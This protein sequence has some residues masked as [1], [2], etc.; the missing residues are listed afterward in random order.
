MP[1]HQSSRV[2]TWCNG[3]AESRRH[4]LDEGGFM[5]ILLTLENIIGFK[6]STFD[7][8]QS[9]SRRSKVD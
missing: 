7:V 4:F 6:S 2:S 9:N 3:G 1:T 5:I 8:G